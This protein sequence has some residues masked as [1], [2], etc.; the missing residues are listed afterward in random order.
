MSPKEQF[1]SSDQDGGS[2]RKRFSQRDQEAEMRLIEQ[3]PLLGS[4]SATASRFEATIRGRIGNP[5]RLD[6][7]YNLSQ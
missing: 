2:P 6:Q 5:R 1:H 4:I 7:F 3:H